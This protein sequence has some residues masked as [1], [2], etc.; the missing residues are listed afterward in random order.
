M[1]KKRKILISKINSILFSEKDKSYC[2]YDFK[3]KRFTH[4]ISPASFMPLFCS[5]ADNEKAECM[6]EKAKDPN[7]FY[8]GIPTISYNNKR[9]NS[10]KY[11]RGPCWLNTAYSAIHG[12]RNYGNTAL[13]NGLTENVLNFCS[14]NKDFIYEYYDSKTGKGLGAKDFGW[15]S[16]F[17]LELIK[18]KYYC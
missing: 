4:R 15:S 16:A 3:L 12:I 17:I 9:Y 10:S 14:Q 1:L 6:I 8:P 7:F 13:A 11:W 2:D 18:E 5:A